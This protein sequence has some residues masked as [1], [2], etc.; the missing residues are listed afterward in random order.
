MSRRCAARFYVV[1]GYAMTPTT[2]VEAYNP[3][4]GMWRSV[5]DVA[6]AMQHPNVGVARDRIFVAGFFLGQGTGSPNPAVYAYDP[7]LDRWDAVSPLPTGTERGA[8]CVAVMND[9]LYV[10][11]GGR[12]GMSVADAAVYDPAVDTWTKLPDMPVRREHCAAG[13]IGGKIYIA[14]GRADGITGF[15]P[16]S[17]VFDPA[18]PGYTSTKPIP[19][20]RGGV[21]AAVLHDKLYVFGGEGNAASTAGVFPNA[22]EYDPATDSWRALPDLMMPRHGFGAAVIGNRIYLPGGAS[23]QGGGAV[24]YGSVYTVE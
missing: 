20:P 5:A 4:T 13:A 2:T 3:T 7:D 14:A 11:G 1:G 21:A 8:A 23:R 10:F 9:K 16:T 22:D 6:S 12:G 15:E 24:A 18:N 19:T 17:F